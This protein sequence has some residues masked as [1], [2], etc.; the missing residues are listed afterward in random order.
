MQSNFEFGPHK[1][2]DFNVNLS[3]DVLEITELIINKGLEKFCIPLTS[4]FE[5]DKIYPK[6]FRLFYTFHDKEY[7]GGAHGLFGILQMIMIAYKL[8]KSKLSTKAEL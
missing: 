4:N 2:T 6:G 5:D 7:F 3:E 1:T 8:N